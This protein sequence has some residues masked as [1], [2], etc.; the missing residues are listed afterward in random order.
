MHRSLKAELNE[1]VQAESRNLA[2]VVCHLR[3]MKTTDN[4][5]DVAAYIT[6][7]KTFLWSIGVDHGVVARIVLKGTIQGLNE[8]TMLVEANSSIVSILQ[9]SSIH[10][11]HA[12]SSITPSMSPTIASHAED[13]AYICRD[14]HALAV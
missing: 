12:G 10:D 6:A 8:Y 7:Y 2:H 9:A 4:H 11:A 1:I 14:L 5:E 13:L 3:C